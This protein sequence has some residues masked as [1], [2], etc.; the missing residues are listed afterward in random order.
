MLI[1]SSSTSSM[2]P[3]VIFILILR[4]LELPQNGMKSTV[5]SYDEYVSDSNEVLFQQSDMYFNL[6]SASR[7]P[8]PAVKPSAGMRPLS[9]Y[10]PILTELLRKNYSTHRMERCIG[11]TL[12]P[13]FNSFFNKESLDIVPRSCHLLA[14]DRRF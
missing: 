9:V 6:Y 8:M 4:S 14:I 10:T 3:A 5:S 13:S 12:I 2:L 7:R 1:A 11:M